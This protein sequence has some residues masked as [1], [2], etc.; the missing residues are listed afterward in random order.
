MSWDTLLSM[1][2]WWQHWQSGW[3]SDWKHV[4]SWWQHWW[5]LIRSENYCSKNT[6]KPAIIHASG[7]LTNTL[8]W[9]YLCGTSGL[10]MNK[11]T[12]SLFTVTADFDEWF[13]KAGFIQNKNTPKLLKIL[14]EDVNTWFS[15]VMYGCTCYPCS[16]NFICVCSSLPLEEQR[17]I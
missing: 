6:C 4:G 8:L 11:Y 17:G 5:H 1:A 9:C 7:I 3:S 14:Y 13:Y 15:K 16:S 12:R 2:W 10:T